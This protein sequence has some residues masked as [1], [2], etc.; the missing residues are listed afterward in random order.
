MERKRATEG[1]RESLRE[2]GTE[3]NKKREREGQIETETETETEK[4]RAACT[5]TR[6]G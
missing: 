6:P 2:G 4:A 1:L 3:R 5:L